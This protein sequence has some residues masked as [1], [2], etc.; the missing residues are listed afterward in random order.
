MSGY[1][2]MVTLSGFNIYTLRGSVADVQE[3]RFEPTGVR[4]VSREI[5]RHWHLKKFAMNTFVLRY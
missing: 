2:M 3:N 5:I 4:W 1:I